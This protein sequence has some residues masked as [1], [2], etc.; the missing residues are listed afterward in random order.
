MEKRGL[1]KGLS[2]LIPQQ[3]HGV[4]ARS[5]GITYIKIGQIQP[6]PNQPREDFDQ[7]S[8]EDLIASIKIKGIIQP[9]LVRPVPTGYQLIAGERRFCAAKS[10]HI[11]EIPA[12]IKDVKDLE[13]LEISLIENIQR[14]DLNVMEE[15]CAYKHLI[16]NFG[17]T[18]DKVAQA[19]G[20]ARVSVANTLRLLKLPHDVQDMLRKGQISFAHGKVL[21]ETED[22]QRQQLLARQVVSAGLSVKELEALMSPAH[23]SKKLK[24]E[25]RTAEHLKAIEEEL[26]QI[27]GTKVKITSGHKR[28]VVHIEFYS[29]D[30]LE[31]IY[32]L[33]KK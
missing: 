30:D 7:E 29:H 12:I 14:Q 24:K 15:A 22:G 5:G 19:I 4:G 6:N 18:Q 8:L 25:N 9:V 11:N 27:L 1:G 32:R 16:E 10:L 3:E 31:R 20:K 28:G 26:Q 23:K 17:F 2:A 21:L 13:S 33:I